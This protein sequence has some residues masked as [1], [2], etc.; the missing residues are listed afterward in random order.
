MKKLKQIILI[1]SLLMGTSIFGSEQN[2]DIIKEQK[3]NIE[4]KMSYIRLD[5]G[6]P[7][8]FTLNFG[9][10]VQVNRH[11]LDISAG[12]TFFPGLYRIQNHIDY[13]FFPKPNLESQYYLGIGLQSI[14]ILSH[15]YAFRHQPEI[16]IGKE[17]IKKNGKKRFLEI[18]IGY[19]AA[20]KRSYLPKHHEYLKKHTNKWP[21]IYLCHGIE[22]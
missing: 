16:M 11:G 2:R 10:R 13:I 14:L 20:L 17:Y 6:Y 15:A 7:S 4:K 1:S 19:Y 5:Y 21:M 18:K 8:L 9:K 3:I 22:F 12:T